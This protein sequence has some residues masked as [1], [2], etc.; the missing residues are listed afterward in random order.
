MCI[1]C[2]EPIE[3]PCSCLDGKHSWGVTSTSTSVT[4]TSFTMTMSTIGQYSGAWAAVDE[5]VFVQGYGYYKVTASTNSTITVTEPTSPFVGGAAFAVNTVDF[6]QYVVS[7]INTPYSIPSGTKVTPAGLKGTTGS[8]GSSG[9]ALV[10]IDYNQ[11]GAN[12]PT[13]QTSFSVVQETVTIGSTTRLSATGDSLRI[14]AKFFYNDTT[15]YMGGNAVGKVVLQQTS[16]GVT[17]A[18]DLITLS[19]KNPGGIIDVILSRDSSGNTVSYVSER[20]K[21][22]D[23]LFMYSNEDM[24]EDIAYG[25]TH[26]GANAQGGGLINF[27]ADFSIE[28]WGKVNPPGA[29]DEIKVGFYSVEFLKKS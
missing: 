22:T 16:T 5:H 9:A 1:D 25:V 3:N 24:I 10:G 21:A 14:K 29:P 18:L 17:I 6:Q 27:A 13:S 4:G 8:T 20:R 12:N 2:E 11:A 7:G 26:T 28:F 15:S 19:S 23:S